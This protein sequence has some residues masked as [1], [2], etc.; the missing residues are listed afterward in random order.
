MTD[1]IVE[2]R[3]AFAVDVRGVPFSVAAGDR[4]WASDPILKGREAMFRELTVRSSQPTPPPAA[5]AVETASADPGAARRIT[6]PRKDQPE[7]DQPEKE[8]S[9]A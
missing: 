2:A 8:T 7:R 5:A 9:D 3:Q 6:R 1:R 4:F